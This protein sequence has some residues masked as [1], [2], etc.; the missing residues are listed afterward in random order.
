MRSKGGAELKVGLVDIDGHN[1]PNLALMKISA[2]YKQQGDTVEWLFPMG[3]YDRV[4]MAKVF[5]FTK[6][7]ETC[8]KADEIVKGGTGYNLTTILPKGNENIYPDYDLYKIKNVAYGFLTRGCPR[9]CPFCIVGEKE[10]LKSQKVA[11]LDR[12]WNGQREIKLLD[13]NLLACKNKTELL[14][15]L[16]DSKA[17]VDFTQGLDVRLITDKDIE[18][19]KQIKVKMIHFA[20]DRPNDEKKII[21][22][23]KYFKKETCIDR[24]KATVYVLT[25]FETDHEYD[26]YRIYKIKELGYD[27]YVMIYNKQKAP[28]KTR[29][30]QRWVNNKIIFRSCEKFENYDYQI[31]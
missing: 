22:N 28:R 6:D 9:G 27:P 20:W 11:D 4:Y 24:R 1:F 3:Q 17:W 18:L 26:L 21:Q 25:N 2:Y 14:Q 13:P 15:Q 8:I 7:F 23:L 5:D 12:F 10:G 19:I 16:V 31:G 29:L 30:L